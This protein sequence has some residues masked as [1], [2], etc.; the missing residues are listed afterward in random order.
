MKKFGKVLS[1]LVWAGCVGAIFVGA[2]TLGMEDA[3]AAY[4]W[5]ACAE[6]PFFCT[7]RGDGFCDVF[8]AP[9]EL[10]GAPCKC[11]DVNYQGVN[12]CSCQ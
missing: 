7:Q 12:G 11:K 6:D 8:G 9:C 5:H 1:E 10:P 3:A 2:F 4:K